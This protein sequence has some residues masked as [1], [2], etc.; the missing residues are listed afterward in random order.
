MTFLTPCIYIYNTANFSSQKTM[1]T[2]THFVGW[3]PVLSSLMSLDPDLRCLHI[4]STITISTSTAMAKTPATT[5][6]ATAP[7]LTTT[8]SVSEVVAM[9]EVGVAT[10]VRLVMSS[11]H[12]GLSLS[13]ITIG[14]VF[15]KPS[16]VLCTMMLR[17]SLIH[18]SIKEM[19]S[20]ADTVSVPVSTAL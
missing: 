2:K 20:T 6:P 5:P 19:S 10:C 11:G 3:L 9:E 18:C 7:T 16:R 1:Q 8:L 17:V 4:T 15:V 14:Q 13:V 12:S